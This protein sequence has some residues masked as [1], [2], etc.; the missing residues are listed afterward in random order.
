ME[1]ISLTFD[2]ASEFEILET[3]DFEEEVARPES[4]RFFTLDEQLTDYFNAVLPKKNTISKFEYKK[5][6]LEVDRIRDTYMNYVNVSDTDYTINSSRKSIN[7][8][9]VKPIYSKFE[10]APYSYKK[11]WNPL[12]KPPQWSAPNYYSRMLFALPKPYRTSEEGVPLTSDSISVNEDGNNTINSLGEYNRTKGIIHEDGTFNVVKVPVPNTAD[13][14]KTKGFFIEPRVDEIPNPLADHP[15]LSSNKSFSLITNDPLFDVFPTI[16]AIMTHGVP[17]TKFPYT[18]GNR[19][20]KLYDLKLSQIPWNLWR[21]RFPPIETIT[22]T[23]KA[24]SVILSNSNEIDAP[25]ENLIKSYS[26]KWHPGIEPRHWLSMQEDAGNLVVKMLLSQA[27]RSGLLPPKLINDTPELLLRA[28]TPE[29]CFVI[30][31]FERFRESGIYRSPKWSDVEK[32]INKSKPLPLGYCIPISDILQERQEALVGNKRVWEETTGQNMLEEHQK[33]LSKNQSKEKQIV[34]TKYEKFASQPASEL[35]R[36]ILAI[37]RDDERLP[38]D[39]AVA[40]EKL[41]RTSEIKDKIYFDSSDLFL[42]CSHTLAIMKGDLEKDE[43]EFFENW[44]SVNEGFKIC[45]HCG[46]RITA[47]VYAAVDDFDENGNPLISHETMNSNSAFV[48]EGHIV[49]FNASLSQLKSAFKLE[50]TGES[51]LYLLLSL[52]QVL[53]SEAQLIPIIQ[54]IRELTGAL[55]QNTKIAKDKKEI[56]EGALG[57]TGMVILLQT[58]NPFLIPRRSFGSKVLK[59][60]G[61]PRD[62]DETND[63]PTLDVIISVLKTTFE[64]TPGTFKG[65]IATFLRKL[66]SKPKEIRKD[67]V[68]NIKLAHDKKFKVQFETAK[69]RYA[70]TPAKAEVVETISF[71]VLKLDKTEYSTF[72]GIGI[73][74]NLGKCVVDVS[75]SYLAAKL[76]PSVK[77][78]SVLLDRT[79]VSKSS[80]QIMAVPVNT[81]MIKFSEDDINRRSKLKF[82]KVKLDKIEA[83]LKGSHDGVAY[84]ALYNRILDMLS[85]QKFSIQNLKEHRNVSVYLQTLIN[86]SL[87]RDIVRGLITELIIEIS[88]TKSLI[89]FLNE[90]CKTDLGF[91]MI[92]TSK[93]EATKQDS[94][95]RTRERE[96]FKQRMRQMDDTNREVTKMLLDIGLAPYVIT[97]EDREMFKREYNYSD[98][99]EEYNRAIALDPDTLIDTDLRIHEDGNGEPLREEEG[100]YGEQLQEL[101]SRG[102][103][104]LGNQEE[105]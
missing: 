41:L 9:W 105:D 94:E 88:K 99:E 85:I 45:N 35:R 68:M 4:L 95:L 59:L 96:T 78:D 86:P 10:L 36:M 24:L 82:P 54:F 70:E 64:S 49:T 7:V 81:K 98:P 11:D 77:Q 2:P 50:N 43:K 14:I 65:A 56:L 52:F 27:F 28:S 91:K 22:E 19:F 5:I 60:T 79:G 23:P 6:A 30:D 61:F 57:V 18:E 16:E 92:L 48:G 84:L 93:E 102:D 89:E 67:C 37:S 8:P 87:L 74:G 75:K 53:P 20:L 103:Y 12:Y 26:L 34:V 71:P 72:E 21:E 97:N 38:E 31:D 51:V 3:F 66:I 62:T 42:I 25:S 40:I 17:I 1:S 32:A 13:D 104:E 33:L 46:E 29:E 73:E 100:T 83:F 58:H 39:K 101:H 15:F 44:T 47:A 63:S 76:P 69:T 90:E 55:K 80:T